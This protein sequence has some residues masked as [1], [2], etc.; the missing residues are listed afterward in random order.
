MHISL[1]TADTS[2]T[3]LQVI[4]THAQGLRMILA[5]YTAESEDED[6]GDGV[7]EADDSSGE[8]GATIKM[9]TRHAH[10]YETDGH[11]TTCG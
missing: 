7:N 5:L 9:C 2:L 10:H 11:S 1:N 4:L 8:D 6:D 3:P